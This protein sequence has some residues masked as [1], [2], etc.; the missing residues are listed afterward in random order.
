LAIA[1]CG[2]SVCLLPWARAA[3]WPQFRGP[4]RD[5][6]S[7]ET[8]LAA[9]WPK[10]SPPVVWRKKI[11]TGYSG[12]VVAGDSLIL[13]H[14]VGAQEVVQCFNAATG[15]ALW[16]FAY[17]TAYQDD[18]GKGD[19]PR[20]T[21]VVAGN[22]VFTLGAEGMLHCVRLDNGKK[23]WGRSILKDYDVPKNFFGVGT[24]PL[25]DDKRLLLNVGGKG[26]GILASARNRGKEVWKATDDGASYSS[27]VPA[28]IDGVRHVI[29][30]TRQGVV[31]VDPA[32]GKVRFRKHW[33]ARS[34]A[35]VNAAT[36]VVVKNLVFISASYETG[37]VL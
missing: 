30:L 27:P 31:S 28:T 5:G 32:R 34:S 8:G 1:F 22:Q 25:I 4:A 11:G 7:P 10:D 16:Q 17:A 3:D 13:F 26:A 33:R 2:L 19:G 29:F 15:N 24:T 35:S 14:R 18:F 37:A 23:L 20:S 9:S 36:P 21:P 12:P 6:T